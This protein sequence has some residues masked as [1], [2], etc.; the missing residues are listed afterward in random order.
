MNTYSMRAGIALTC[1]GAALLLPA[2]QSA[3][4]RTLA[5]VKSLGAISMC[6]N[7]DALPYA[8]NKPETP[9]FQ[10][11]IGRAIAEGLGVPLSIEWIL[12]RRR[13][14]VVNCDLMLDSINDPA[15]QEGRLRLSRPYQKSGL[16]LGLGRDAEV[17]SD[18]TELK[19]G[20]K[21]GVMSSSFARMVL[22]KAGK[23]TSPYAFQSDMVEDL[24][25]GELYGAAVSMPTMSYYILQ[26]PESGLSL[27]NAFDSNPQLNW[28]VAVGLRKS[29][30][31]LVDAVNEIL[32]KLIADGSL[33]RIYAKYGVEHRL[34]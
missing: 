8:S 12:P 7:A 15:V 18:F 24:A 16:A 1:L 29:D 9:G 32:E 13:A 26:H 2:S 20:Q 3:V 31:A 28:E 30:Q 33:T 4:A 22:D 25:K 34:P 14:N 27:V 23:T 5:E 21:I 17:I 11:E 19:K 10:I 6:A